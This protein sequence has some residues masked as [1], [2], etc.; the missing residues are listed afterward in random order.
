[1]LTKYVFVSLLWIFINLKKILSHLSSLDDF[2][3]F[4]F[5]CS[6]CMPM[7]CVCISVFDNKSLVLHRVSLLLLL[8]RKFAI[9]IGGVCARARPITYFINFSVLVS[10]LRIYC[11][12]H[13]IFIVPAVY[14]SDALS[15][16]RQ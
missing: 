3:C 14:V 9:D 5:H 13:F 7:I 15:I 6:A 2:M 8:F 10:H 1:M 4:K 12:M 16:M 11:Y